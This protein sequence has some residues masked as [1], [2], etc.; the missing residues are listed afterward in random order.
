MERHFTGLLLRPSFFSATINTVITI[1]VIGLAGGADLLEKASFYAYLFGEEGIFKIIT[2]T[3]EDGGLLSGIFS[4]NVLIL[5]TAVFV[6]VVVY[7]ILQL[8]GRIA[9]D[10][11][12][13]WESLH[14]QTESGIRAI[15][16]RAGIRVLVAVSWI[17]Y[18]VMFA[19]VIMPFCVLAAQVGVREL[20]AVGGFAYLAF[21]SLLLWLA[22]HL[23]SIFLRLLFLRPRV[24]GGNDDILED[25]FRHRGY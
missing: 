17:I 22:L 14:A 9:N 1:A 3:G 19:K 7:I 23:H 21:G 24:F 16:S 20:W 6:G 10:A 18:L 13:T 25:E 12:A 4:Y 5:A 15:A 2:R 8:M 11:S